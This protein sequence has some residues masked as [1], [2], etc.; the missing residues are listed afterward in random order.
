MKNAIFWHVMPCGSF[1]KR[2]FVG[3]YRL[4]HQGE[5]TSE[6]EAMLALTT[7]RSTLRRNSFHPE[8]GIDT[9]Q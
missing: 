2:P 3:T 9:F 7:N 5:K 1:M 4:H 8:D 6:L